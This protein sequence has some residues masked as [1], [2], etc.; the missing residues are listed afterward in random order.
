MASFHNTKGIEMEAYG[1]A[2]AATHA[3]DSKPFVII[4]KSVCDFADAMLLNIL[5][6]IITQ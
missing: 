5:G 1:V 3:A 2:Y 6:V 4:A